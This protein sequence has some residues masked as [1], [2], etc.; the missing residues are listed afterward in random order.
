MI[1]HFSLKKEVGIEYMLSDFTKDD[2]DFIISTCSI[3]SSR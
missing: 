1:L 2:Y 3:P